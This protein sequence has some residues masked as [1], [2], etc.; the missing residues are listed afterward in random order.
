MSANFNKDPEAIENFTVDWTQALNGDTIASSTWSVPT[1]I[2]Q[3]AAS[4]TTTQAT[5]KL[6]GGVL[7]ASYAVVNRITTTTSGE[8][9]DE[10][11]NIYIVEQ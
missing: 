8:T 9:L 3:A 1:G 5:I 2:T 6:S 10:T 4:N 11:L 7:G